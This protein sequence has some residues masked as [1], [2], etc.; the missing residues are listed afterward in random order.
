MGQQKKYFIEDWAGKRYGHLVIV[1]YEKKMFIC[2]CDCGNEKRVKPTFLFNGHQTTCGMK[3]K[4]HQSQYDRRSK[5][6]LYPVWNSMM[7]RC[8]NPKAEGYYLYGGRGIE[9]CDEWKNDFWK[10]NEW[11]WKTGYKPG[12][13]ID[14]ID[15]DG[16][17]EP[18]N[19]RWATRQQ[20]AN[21]QHER[22]SFKEKPTH[23]KSTGKKYSVFGENLT[24][25]QIAE[26]YGLTD[27][28]IRYR[29][30]RGLTIEEAA[31]VPKAFGVKLQKNLKKQKS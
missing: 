11:S 2:K 13:T 25:S 24:I 3:C 10:F 26:K 15:G 18:G 30:K 14:R 29:L 1:G 23:Y 5:E 4:Y 20:Q 9:V 7:Q 12:L 27:Q 6:I 19:C 16:N 28:V 17:Y 31:T 22:Y 21:N 8:Y